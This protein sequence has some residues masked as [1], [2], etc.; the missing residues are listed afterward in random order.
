[1]GVVP[2]FDDDSSFQDDPFVGS[3]EVVGGVLSILCVSLPQ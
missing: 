1:M 3:L 2:F